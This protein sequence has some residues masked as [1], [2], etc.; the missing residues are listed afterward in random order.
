MLL[1]REPRLTPSEDRE[2]HLRDLG[3][4]LG[5]SRIAGRGNDALCN[6]RSVGSR[7]H[8]FPRVVLAAASL[9][10]RRAAK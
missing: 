2:R 5:R 3:R 7:R 1:E 10:R 6:E 8:V 9:S 4:K